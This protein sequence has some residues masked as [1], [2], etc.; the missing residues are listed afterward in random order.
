MPLGFFRPYRL[1]GIGDRGFLLKLNRLRPLQL[2]RCL[3]IFSDGLVA[4]CLGIFS[5]GILGVAFG[6]S[7]SENTPRPTGNFA[8]SNHWAIANFRSSIA[9]HPAGP[10]VA[11]DTAIKTSAPRAQARIDTLAIRRVAN[12]LVGLW[13]GREDGTVWLLRG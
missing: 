3:G 1:G 2:T 11:K 10:K 9:A 6:K 8:D 7:S 4:S 5:G 13:G 12:S